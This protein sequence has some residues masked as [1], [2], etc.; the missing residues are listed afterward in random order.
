MC[1]CV[2]VVVPPYSR[3]CEASGFIFTADAFILAGR[4]CLCHSRADFNVHLP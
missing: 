2:C 3:L 4:C 1:V